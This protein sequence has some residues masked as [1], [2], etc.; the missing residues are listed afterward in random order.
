MATFSL[1]GLE[2]L[3]LT[4]A[5]PGT[6]PER[7]LL[8]KPPAAAGSDAFWSPYAM[9][10]TPAD[11][12]G[13][14]FVVRAARLRLSGLEIEFSTIN[15]IS[16]QVDQVRDNW[17][18]VALN[19]RMSIRVG[20]Q[21]LALGP[22]VIPSGVEPLVVA[23]D[24]SDSRA[25]GRIYTHYDLLTGSD[26]T[27]APHPISLALRKQSGFS[28]DLK[29]REMNLPVGALECKLTAGKIERAI[30]SSHVS[31][32]S[33]A[34]ELRIP[35]QEVAAT[36][37][38]FT[39]IQWVL[40]LRTGAVPVN[41]PASGEGVPPIEVRNCAVAL[42]LRRG[43]AVDTRIGAAGATLDAIALRQSASG[44]MRLTLNAVRDTRNRPE[45]WTCDK[46]LALGF[47]F[48]ESHVPKA[49]PWPSPLILP[50][51]DAVSALVREG[52]KES[53]PGFI[54]SWFGGARTQV[55][56]RTVAEIVCSR[57]AAEGPGP[58]PRFVNQRLCWVISRP[59]MRLR[60]AA[61]H[62]N[63]PGD[64][65]R[66][67][68][69]SWRFESAGNCGALP[70]LS[71]KGWRAAAPGP[72]TV[73]NGELD[74]AHEQLKLS[75]SGAVHE[76]GLAEGISSSIFVKA[77]VPGAALK[78]GQLKLSVGHL[79]FEMTP[80][81]L[82]HLSIVQTQVSPVEH[83]KLVIK[84]SIPTS[85]QAAEYAVFW[86][87]TIWKRN[88]EPTTVTSIDDWTVSL[89]GPIDP[90]A[91]ILV[92]DV[93][94]DPGRPT[95][96]PTAV[97]KLGRNMS[98]VQLLDDIESRIDDSTRKAAFNKRKQG[99]VKL[100]ELVDETAVR[101]D[102]V[103][104]FIFDAPVDYTAFP[105]LQAL[106]PTQGSEA[107][108]LE[109]LA[110]S[111][112]QPGTATTDVAVSGAIDWVNPL[113]VR[114][115]PRSTQARGA[116][117]EA[118]IVSRSLSVAFRERKIVRFEA[119]ATLTFY[120]FFAVKGSGSEITDINIVGSGRRVS[121]GTGLDKEAYEIRF[122]AETADQAKLVV[123]PLGNKP[124]PQDS[125]SFVKKV[126]LRR[127]EIVDGPR[128]D[129]P[130]R[131][132][133]VQ[134]DGAIEFGRPSIPVPDAL[135]DFFSKLR[136]VSF[137]NLRID[138]TAPS[139][140]NPRLL[141]LKY[142]SLTFNLDLPH[143]GLLGNALKLKFNRL[144]IDWSGGDL[145][146][147]SFPRI[148]G[149]GGS[150]GDNFNMSLPKLAFF[151]KID[152]GSLPDMFARSLS[153]FSLEG[154]FGINF[155]NGMPVGGPYIGLGGFGFTGLNFDLLSFLVLRADS[156][157]LGPR[158]WRKTG[159][160]DQ[161]GAALSLKNLSVTVLGVTVLPRGS[162]GF[163]SLENDGGEG[164]WALLQG[165]EQRSPL[166]HVDW[167]FVA[168]N[169]DFD[170]E[171]AKEMLVPP[172]EK[173][174]RTEGFED[175]HTTLSNA[176]GKPQDGAEAERPVTIFPARGQ[177][178][179][180]WTFAASVQALNGAFFGRALIQDGG[181][182]G[183]AL[184]GK[185]FKELFNWDFVFVGIYR[186]NI[187]PGEDYFYFSITLPPFTF[188][189]I[190]F[191]GGTIAAEFFTSG[192][193]TA[194]VGFPWQAP[195]GG[196]QWERTLGA[197]ITPGQASAGF[198]LRKRETA[199]ATV[200]NRLAV[201]GGF[202]LQWGLGAT[203]GGGI[204]TVWVRVGIY[205]IL[206]GRVDL[207]I[208]AGKARLHAF[209]FHGAAGVLA[210]GY[211]E[212]NWWVISVRVSV[213]ASAEIRASLI[214]EEGKKMWMP[215]EAE[216]FASARAE[217]CIG[218]SCVRICRGI[219]VSLSLPVRYQLEFG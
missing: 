26:E 116:N 160:A 180:G 85:G 9:F 35:F 93:A 152:F 115:G 192:D 201:S 207:I 183:I 61:F 109:F 195:G 171:V 126:W 62:H 137:T 173:E 10:L 139:G 200:G 94:N 182:A 204:F 59:W 47:R 112:R 145:D 98:L 166:F 68:E 184:Y 127:V 101:K 83:G 197:I 169:V 110:I 106:L 218:G 70:L 121:G 119:R 217:A 189:T 2:D 147:G 38:D 5:T 20:P 196:R 102:W 16:V 118:S 42:T 120:S 17:R 181:F 33:N 96:L 131:L 123:F 140:L 22:C 99:L 186:H 41:M 37:R 51:Q 60:N 45:V 105:A 81:A 31:M 67:G 87:G 130:D 24:A 75:S 159:F 138:L 176:W 92:G 14:Q 205:V 79:Q 19:S 188:G 1:F 150:S 72:Q 84:T 133:E 55:S 208:E 53:L 215:I 149:L 25:V 155:D 142:P 214:W 206:E 111:P 154:V 167:A 7:S 179:R 54:H 21:G 3:E 177:G 168:H 198:Y 65:Y 158:T 32:L 172:P 143:V 108:R 146:L 64:S 185:L 210:E 77:V 163:F 97:L 132:P 161:K 199:L 66:D 73:G 63:R 213:R 135:A 151:G 69:Y 209:A 114:D 27:S 117:Q 193:F 191:M 58:I 39:A 52:G 202:A 175:L 95:S 91:P 203:F 100:I 86:P 190:H 103:G 15:P 44:P 156:L 122:A 211:G 219:S 30:G 40:D 78:S 71:S 36:I 128:A 144:G 34:S 13:Y 57:A 136:D 164:F 80:A 153:G 157:M 28:L 89:R 8:V 148:G 6:L 43:M 48:A 134:I 129:G 4:A 90:L 174:R 23:F 178:G 104:L 49:A 29:R 113:T 88:S 124:L 76:S 141:N 125:P 56:K 50:G 216:L 74:S 212:L 170:A 194:D 12:G 18:P 165:P 162:G 82:P 107:P 187:T 46:P 11:G